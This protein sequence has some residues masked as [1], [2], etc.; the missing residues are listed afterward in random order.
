MAAA[1]LGGIVLGLCSPVAG[2]TT[3]RSFLA[4]GF[5]VAGS[6][7]LAGILFTVV[8]RMALAATTSLFAWMFLGLVGAR[9]A[10]Q[11]RP[12]DHVLNLVTTG[13]IDL[14]TPLG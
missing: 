2:H 14:H 13:R 12:A 4:A 6:L 5:L 11:P 8:G 9:V 7:V 1:F 3:S 10:E